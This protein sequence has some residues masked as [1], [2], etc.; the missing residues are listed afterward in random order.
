V[1]FRSLGNALEERV[2]KAR[3][4]VERNASQVAKA[5][6]DMSSG[7]PG[8]ARRLAAA[9]RRLEA[10]HSELQFALEMQRDAGDAAKD[11]MT[12]G[13]ASIAPAP[14]TVP[15]REQVLQVLDAVEV[16][17][18]G[19]VIANLGRARFDFDLNSREMASLRRDDH[20]RI[21]RRDPHSRPAYIAPAI[22]AQRLTP[23]TRLFTSSA[24]SPLQRLVG[25]RSARADHLRTLLRLLA[26]YEERDTHEMEMIVWRFA[27]NVPDAL[28][29]GRPLDVKQARAATEHEFGIIEPLDLAER[30]TAAS[31]W[32]A[33]PEHERIWGRPI[34][35]RLR[36]VE[37]EV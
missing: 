33:L 31:R 18:S 20:N 24:W 16:P 34:G 19:G 23:M 17:L 3:K 5:A 30:E 22:D 21:Y 12:S 25:V 37:G 15:K 36:V 6:R 14:G 1:L 35:D 28:S 4:A 11:A 10:A 32:N 2:E 8:V 27:R 7:D 26:I 29:P 13:I 9:Q